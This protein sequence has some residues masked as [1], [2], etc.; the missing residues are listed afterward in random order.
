MYMLSL[1]GLIVI[2]MLSVSGLELICT[3]RPI[4]REHVP[5]FPTFQLMNWTDGW[6][7]KRSAVQNFW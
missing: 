3:C 6:M 5:M 7:I 2:I 4:V 1:N